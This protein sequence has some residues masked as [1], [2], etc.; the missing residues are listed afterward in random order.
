MH[1][2]IH[3]ETLCLTLTFPNPNLPQDGDLKVKDRTM[4]EVALSPSLPELQDPL[5]LWSGK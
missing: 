4:K 1:I 2:D 5:T 3:T